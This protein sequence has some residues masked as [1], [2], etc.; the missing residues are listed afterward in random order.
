MSQDFE[1]SMTDTTR[2]FHWDLRN[3]NCQLND[4][5]HF[6]GTFHCHSSA[7]GQLAI[8]LILKNETRNFRYDHFVLDVQYRRD[9]HFSYPQRV[10]NLEFTGGDFDT[11]LKIKKV[12]NVSFYE[13]NDK[14]FTVWRE[15]CSLNGSVIKE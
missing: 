14:V 7:S 10:I 4:N 12:V 6:A 13:G 8:E 3:G 11:P 9:P 5:S 1:F 2:K 15:S